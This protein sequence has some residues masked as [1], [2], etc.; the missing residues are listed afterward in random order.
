MIIKFGKN[1]ELSDWTDNPQDDVP[2]LKSV[3]AFHRLYRMKDNRHV[4]GISVKEL[5]WAKLIDHNYERCYAM[6]YHDLSF[7][8][9]Y[10][11]H[12]IEGNL[13]FAKEF[14]D[15]FLIKMSGLTA[16]I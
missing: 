11:P 6:F 16:F 13:D 12:N 5:T 9:D 14:V 10:F 2:Q 4:I 7:C 8:H 15:N 3:K 1:I